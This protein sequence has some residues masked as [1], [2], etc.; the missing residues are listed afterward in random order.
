MSTK[1]TSNLRYRETS[2]FENFIY[3][4]KP[5]IWMAISSVAFVFCNKT[6]KLAL[7]SCATLFVMALYIYFARK[8]FR[9]KLKQQIL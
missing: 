2:N 5:F 4:S 3:E 9:K 1:Y 6:D 8:T 7:A